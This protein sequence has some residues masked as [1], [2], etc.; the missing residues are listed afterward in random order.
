MTKQAAFWVQELRQRPF[1][2]RFL[3]AYQIY[4]TF[5]SVPQSIRKAWAWARAQ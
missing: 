1:P 4:R 2:I 5:C 3:R